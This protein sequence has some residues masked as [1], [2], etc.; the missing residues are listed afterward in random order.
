MERVSI[1][2]IMI[3]YNAEK[4]VR[5]ALDSV[6]N[7]TLRDIEIICVDD[8]SEDCTLNIFEEYAKRD[9]R[10]RVMHHEK[11]MGSFAARYTGIMEA[12][13]DYTIFIDPDDELLE[14]ACECLSV[15]VARQKKDVLQFGVVVKAETGKSV[16]LSTLEGI[17]QRMKV[18]S[19]TF[20]EKN[21]EKGELLKTCYIDS[22]IPFN[23]WNKIYR[24]DILKKAHSQYKGERV[25]MADDCLKTFMILCYTQS[26]GI[27]ST[28][29][30][31]YYVGGG[32]STEVGSLSEKK[33]QRTAEEYQVYTLAKT[34]VKQ[35]GV[36]ARYAL[37]SLQK[38]HTMVSDAIFWYFFHETTTE[39]YKLFHKYLAQ[40][41]P[42]DEFVRDI[43]SYVFEHNRLNQENMALRLKNY[44]A[45]CNYSKI[46]QVQTVG[47]FYH[48]LHNGGIERVI[49]LLAPI[50]ESCGYRVVI[51][52]DQKQ[53]GEN[54]ELPES[55]ILT[56]LGTKD[57]KSTD[58]MNRFRQ[59]IEK[60]NID[61]MIYHAWLSDTIV[62]DALAIKSLSIPL[63]LHTHS[64]ATVAFEWPYSMWKNQRAVYALFDKVLTLSKVDQA[65]WSALGF[66]AVQI[67]NPPTYPIQSTPVA[68]NE[69]HNCVWIGRLNKVEKQY[70]DAFEV[71]RYVHSQIPDFRLMVVG[72]TESQEEMNDIIEYL[73]NNDMAGYVLLYGFQADVRPFYQK[74]SV[75]LSTSSVEGCPMT[76]VESKVFGLPMV[77]YDLP[78]DFIREPEGAFVVKQHDIAQAGEYIIE[79]MKNDNLR[80]QMGLKARESVERLYK[81]GL[82]HTWQE[83]IEHIAF[84]PS[85]EKSGH[86][87]PTETAICCA[88]DSFLKG[89]SASGPYISTVNNDA[90]EYDVLYS[91][92]QELWLRFEEAAKEGKAAWEKYEA[93]AREA[94]VVWERYEAASAILNS[95]SYRV[96]QILTW[97]IRKLKQVMK[98]IG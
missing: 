47:M 14:N 22:V 45:F 4:T 19:S 77:A 80:I 42:T 85:C 44:P 43:T 10:I 98:R 1:S 91:Q 17:R 29:F 56:S 46:K 2:V 78:I 31:I 67:V 3:A 87:S 84:R 68:L 36:P 32:M 18:P 96:Y 54:Y 35:T 82:E 64:K 26:Y 71:A 69:N 55:V 34:W 13:G 16:P 5:R 6:V 33:M 21:F 79:L 58:R 81:D 72:K 83:I 60:H 63:V 53:N 76:Y 50:L 7:Q 59:I 23:V 37:A 66:D 61:V 90:R 93:T 57:I 25:L 48:R 51:I 20:F 62:Y 86:G 24:T 49:S 28:P 75:Y 73:Q 30:Y 65:W 11:N 95:R 8:C 89:I 52:T 41:Y 9:P 70:Y 40:H 94:K 74:A 92:Y 88:V 97:P 27:C 39:N 12:S 15:E 38:I